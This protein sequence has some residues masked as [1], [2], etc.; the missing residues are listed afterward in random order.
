MDKV[1]T[2]FEI[3]HQFSCNFICKFDYLYFSV[4]MYFGMIGGFLFI[5]IQLVLII[6]FA[7]SWAE[8]WV[9]K[10]EETESKA[11]Y[12]G[13]MILCLLAV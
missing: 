4:W 13:K 11:Y 2:V 9:A 12:C 6:D 7:H 5:L 8:N 10:L 1:S 3:W